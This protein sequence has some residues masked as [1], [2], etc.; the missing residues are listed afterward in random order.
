VPSVDPTA[1][2]TE[3]EEDDDDSLPWEVLPVAPTVTTT[4]VEEDIDGGPLGRCCW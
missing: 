1:G 3:V 4:E 2:T